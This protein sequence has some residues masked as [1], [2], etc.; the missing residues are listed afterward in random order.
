MKLTHKKRIGIIFIV[1]GSLGIGF[2]L[3]GLFILHC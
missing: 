2:Y 1:I 3:I